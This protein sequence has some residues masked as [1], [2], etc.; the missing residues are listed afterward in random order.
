MHKQHRMKSRTVQSWSHCVAPG[1]CSGIEHGGVVYVETCSC[2]ATRQIEAN[3]GRE[4]KSPWSEPSE[5]RYRGALEGIRFTVR[6]FRAKH[7]NFLDAAQ[8]D[9]LAEID[10]CLEVLK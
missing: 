10:I 9:F 7:Y 1:V 6:T 4:A 5:D 2:G 8:R 3:G